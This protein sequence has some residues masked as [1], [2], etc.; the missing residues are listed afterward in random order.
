[1]LQFI[2]IT[3]VSSF[4]TFYSNYC[5]GISISSILYAFI[6]I[7]RPEYAAFGFLSLLSC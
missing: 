1:M 3:S 2:L 7:G 6:S 4:S 5:N